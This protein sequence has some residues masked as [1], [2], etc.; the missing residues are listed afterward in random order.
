MKIEKINNKNIFIFGL[1]ISGMSLANFLKNKVNNLFC[2]D[3]NLLIRK[4]GVKAGLN[5]KSVESLNFNSLDYLVLS[6]GINHRLKT[7]HLVVSEALKK[8]VKITTDLEFLKILQIKNFLIGVTGT[9]GKSTTTKFIEKSL[10]FSKSKCITF[11]NIGIPFGDIVSNL[12]K[13]D[14]LLAEVSSFQ[15]DKIINLKFGI[16]ILLNLSKDHIEWHGGWNEYLKSKFKI[17]ENQD[18][19]CFA[20]ICI[21]DKNSNELA[22]NFNKKY[23]SKL[24]KISIKRKLI[25]GIFLEEKENMLV[26]VNNLN[27]TKILI[28]KNKLL[29]TKAHHNYQNLLATYASYFLLKKNNLSF[30]KSIYRLKNLEHRLELVIRVKNICVFNDSKSTNINAA[31]NAIKSFQNIYWILG[32]R[33]KKD[34]INGIQNNLNKILKAFTFGEAGPEFNEFLKNKNVDSKKY[35]CLESALENAL[36]EGFREKAEINILFSPA[37]SSFD[38]FKNFEQRGRCFKK[39]LK[40]ILKND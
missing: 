36:K 34:G 39:Y 20:I 18:K 7:P 26:I 35:K 23:K 27:K 31:K 32:G 37:C 4:K 30:L 33:K 6:P 12:Q 5:L 15:L 28:E 17:F 38:Q 22:K 3:D 40:K 29:F 13:T 1:G 8:K 25:D 16:S 2:W 14:I 9:N 10:M 19:N 24:I 21:D 11:G